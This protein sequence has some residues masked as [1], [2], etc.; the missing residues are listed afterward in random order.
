MDSAA[1]VTNQLEA[2]AV[3]LTKVWLYATMN[4]PILPER[5]KLC[6]LSSGTRA[7]SG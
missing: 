4:S 6:E 1:Q 7:P 3:L 2:P 5:S